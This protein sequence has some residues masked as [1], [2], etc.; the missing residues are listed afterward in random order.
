MSVSSARRRIF[1]LMH[2]FVDQFVFRLL[3]LRIQNIY[4]I[5]YRLQSNNLIDIIDTYHTVVQYYLDN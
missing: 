1:K 5:P 3:D 2:F 4:R